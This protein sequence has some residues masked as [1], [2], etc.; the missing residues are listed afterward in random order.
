MSILLIT[1]FISLCYKTVLKI[2]DKVGYYNTWVLA[3]LLRPI[4]EQNWRAAAIRKDGGVGIQHVNSRKWCT[5]YLCQKKS[6]LLFLLE[7]WF[8]DVCVCV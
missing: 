4:T 6:K 3:K 7:Q 2:L 5:S 8:S 1:P